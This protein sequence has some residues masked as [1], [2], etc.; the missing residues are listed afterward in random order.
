[1][2]NQRQL[3]TA[4]VELSKTSAVVKKAL[5]YRYLIRYTLP[6]LGRG[7]A[8]ELIFPLSRLGR[9]L[10]TEGYS[11]EMM[12]AIYLQDSQPYGLFDRVF[13]GYPLHRAIYHRLQILNH[14]IETELRRRLER[15]VE[16]DIIAIMTAPSGYA[17]DL[18]QPLERIAQ[19]NPKE[20]GAIYMLASDLD[21][22]RRIQGELL[23]AARRAGIGFEFVRGDLASAH[24]RRQLHCTAPYDIVVF[25]GLSTWMPRPYLVSHLR[26]IREGLLAP[27][28]VMFADCFTPGGFALAGKYLGYKANYY[29]PRE[30]TSILAYCGFAPGDIAWEHSP[31]GISHVCAAR[32]ER[33]E[34][35]ELGELKEL[36]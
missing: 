21:P 13:L 26:L 25:V 33:R 14:L 35:R 3:G 34:L 12:K 32:V 1:M 36:D 20:I 28:G 24:V 5:S 22:A 8:R 11:A 4:G 7:S 31:E 16:D 30:F 27:G 6:N 29:Q 18:F 19:S 10:F 15:L 2:E 9:L 23:R 17:F